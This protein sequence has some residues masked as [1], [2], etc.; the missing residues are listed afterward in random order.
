MEQIVKSLES[1]WLLLRGQLPLLAV[2]VSRT[3]WYIQ[4]KGINNLGTGRYFAILT[5]FNTKIIHNWK[6]VEIPHHMTF[7]SLEFDITILQVKFYLPLEGRF[8]TFLEIDMK[9][10]SPLQRLSCMILNYGE[11]EIVSTKVE[12]LNMWRVE[13]SHAI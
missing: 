7:A 9:F 11:I 12:I 4:R 3:V 8:Q 13:I 2:P 6:A 1:C 10:N 5:M